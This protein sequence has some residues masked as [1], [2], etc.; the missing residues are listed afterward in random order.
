MRDLDAQTVGERLDTRLRRGVGG[1]HGGVQ[2][3]GQRGDRQDVAA[4]FGDLRQRGADRPHD[5]EQADLDDAVKSIRVHRRHRRGGPDARVRD[6]G[7]DA[8]EALDRVLDGGLH[9]VGLRDVSFEEDRF[10]AELARA[11]REQV[12]LQADERE[13]GALGAQLAGGLGADPGARR[14]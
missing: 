5:A 7:V 14:P 6:H 2:G 8:A 4:L 11:F 1:L 10:A 13:P 3:G 12:R 9:L